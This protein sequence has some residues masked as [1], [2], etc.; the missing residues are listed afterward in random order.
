MGGPFGMRASEDNYLAGSVNI[1]SSPYLKKN[2]IHSGNGST[3]RVDGYPL[4]RQLYKHIDLKGV[5][6]ILEEE[7]IPLPQNTEVNFLLSSIEATWSGNLGFLGHPVGTDDNWA[8]W[9]GYMGNELYENVQG[10]QMGINFSL[11]RSGLRITDYMGTG[12]ITS[13]PG[14]TRTITFI[15]PNPIF[16]NQKDPNK[17]YFIYKSEY[18][19]NFNTG[20][21]KPGKIEGESIIE[22]TDYKSYK[23][24]AD[25]ET[26]S[27]YGVG[28]FSFRILKNDDIV[29][30][31]NSNSN[32]YKYFI[33]K[34][35][36]DLTN[37]NKIFELTTGDFKTGDQN[38]QTD[39][40][41]KY[42]YSGILVGTTRYVQLG[43][44]HTYDGNQNKQGI[45]ENDKFSLY[46][47]SFDANG[48]ISM[49]ITTVVF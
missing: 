49:N 1:Y 29:Y 40:T 20:K 34:N 7:G 17:Q 46:N 43:L 30:N 25:Y 39:S 36:L 47:T 15:Y 38:I 12:C 5:N 28:D 27:T 45:G 14:E 11:S 8:S 22:N 23:S 31:G 48:N 13:K 3:N 32:N 35:Q 6:R 10:H 4:T 44:L 9:D 42:K 37:P 21:P 19:Y 33:S 26:H 41:F 24:F 18:L 2:I 16:G